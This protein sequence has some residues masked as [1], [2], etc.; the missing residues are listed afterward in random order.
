MASSLEVVL[1]CGTH[2][3]VVP[4]STVK[5]AAGEDAASVK[6]EFAGVAKSTWKRNTL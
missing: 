3:R 4:Q 2:E 1:G 6:V 5:P